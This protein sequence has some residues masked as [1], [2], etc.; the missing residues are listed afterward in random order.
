LPSH[1]QEE[2][3]LGRNSV[4]GCSPFC[5]RLGFGSKALLMVK[6]TCY[7]CEAEIQLEEEDKDAVHPLCADCDNSFDD[8]FAQQ[9]RM[10][11]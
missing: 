7:K 11:K 9:L 3:L 2:N 6:T 1:E 4:D 5:W 10:F 8:W